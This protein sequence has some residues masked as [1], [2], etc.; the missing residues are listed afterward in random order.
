M[1]GNLLEHRTVIFT[2]GPDMLLAAAERHFR[3]AGAQTFSG[4]MEGQTAAD[5][6]VVCPLWNTLSNEDDVG[7]ELYAV[8]DDL[9][10]SK[11]LWDRY[12]RHVDRILP[13]NDHAY[14]VAC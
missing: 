5:V 11:K 12:P 3:T 9:K 1:T 2:H 4:G 10:A 6:L 13:R 7:A 14:S 8:I